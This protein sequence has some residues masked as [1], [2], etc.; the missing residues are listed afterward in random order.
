[1]AATGQSKAEK[2]SR[3]EVLV[4]NTKPSLP[5]MPHMAEDLAALELKLGEVRTLESRQ[6]DL[7]S[8]ARDLVA[9]IRVAAQD[10]EKIRARLGANLRGKFGFESDVLVKYG[11]RP[12]QPI[13]RRRLKAKSDP[14]N[15]QSP[16][17]TKV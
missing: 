13:V 12:R 2:F 15:P 9:R 11:F 10:G 4:T 3:W 17:P 14:T 6:E 16:T 1:M 5:E 8:Q 7:R